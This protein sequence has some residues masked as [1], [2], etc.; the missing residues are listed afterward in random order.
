VNQ[1]RLPAATLYHLVQILLWLLDELV[2]THF[3]REHTILLCVLED[4]EIGFTWHEQAILLNNVDETE[5]KE[6]ERDVHEV[7]CTVGHQANNVGV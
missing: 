4:T 6:V 5:A 2:D 7:W 1:L 3:I